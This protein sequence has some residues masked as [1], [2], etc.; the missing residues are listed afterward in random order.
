MSN[1]VDGK[2][3]FICV[4]DNQDGEMSGHTLLAT[5]PPTLCVVTRFTFA[6][7][8]RFKRVCRSRV[9][10]KRCVICIEGSFH[11]SIAKCQDVSFVSSVLTYVEP[12]APPPAADVVLRNHSLRHVYAVYSF[13][14]FGRALDITTQLLDWSPSYERYGTVRDRLQ[15]IPCAFIFA[16]ANFP[17]AGSDVW[18]Q[19]YYLCR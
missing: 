4:E 5:P 3:V 14:S 19:H 9:C 8:P 17:Y 16:A 7:L 10:D 1:V 6:S 15:G 12:T 18:I 11:S 2:V 13:F